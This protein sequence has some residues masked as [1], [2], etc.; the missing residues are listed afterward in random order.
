MLG[1]SYENVAVLG[2]VQKVWGVAYGR[3]TYV[4]IC[5]SH[6][7]AFVWVRTRVSLAC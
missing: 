7:A 3:T 1:A 4:F 5:Y 6:L 2:T